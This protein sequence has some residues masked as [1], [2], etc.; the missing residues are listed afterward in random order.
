MYPRIIKNRAGQ[1]TAEYVILIALLVLIVIAVLSIAGVSLQ[2][3][4]KG[5]S[6]LFP[7]STE[8]PGVSTPVNPGSTDTPKETETSEP[9]ALFEDN[10][11]D[12]KLSGWLT[13]QASLWKGKWS[14]ADGKAS[15]EPLSAMLVK[16]FSQSD[17]VVTARGVQLKNIKNSYNGFGVYFRANHL[18]NGE[19]Y[20][21]EYEKKN[22]ADPGLI[23]FSKW[24][25]GS[26]LFPPIASA[27]LP[28]D[29]DWNAPHDV[30]VLVEGNTFA[31]YIDGVQALT[32]E[33]DL[34]REGSAGMAVN[35]GS[36]ATIE[37]FTITPLP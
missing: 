14:A 4:Y 8:V 33:D 34:Y 31:A 3:I 13:L 23:F 1:G 37:S 15:G 19:G 36:I 32:G 16:N 22:A 5:I 20:M 17:Y 24:V 18:R 10:F 9:K 12:E 6:S 2:D 35:N 29:F 7:P 27:T 11:L 21:F 26:Q 28:P 25:K 30:Q